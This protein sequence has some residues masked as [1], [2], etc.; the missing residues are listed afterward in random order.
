M[1][2]PQIEEEKRLSRRQFA[3]CIEKSFQTLINYE[4]QG[5]VKPQK[6]ASGGRYYLESDVKKY[7]EGI[8][9]DGKV[10]EN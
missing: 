1:S 10:I 5:I 2:I 6:T 7:F 4:K 3:K 9:A 8:R